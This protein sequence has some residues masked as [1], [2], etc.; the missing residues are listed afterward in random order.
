MNLVPVAITRA[1]GQNSLLLQKNS[2]KILF[3]AGIVGVVGSTVLACRATLKMDEVLSEAQDKMAMARDLD[4]AHYSEA[5][6]RK[7]IT[8]IRVQT[9]VKIVKLY[10]PALVIGG[11]SVAALT[12]SHN[13][14]SRRNAGLTAAYAALERGFDEY[15]AR[16]IA[17]YGEDEDRDLRYGTRE[18]T[19]EEKGKKKK[20]VRVGPGD[21]SIYARFFDVS[22][23]S[24]N[25]DPEYNLI[26][27]KCQQNYANDLLHARGHIFLNEVY[28]MLGIPRSKAGAVVGWVL[29]V[30]DDFVDFG[31]FDDKS[32]KARDFV[33]G[34]EGAILLDFNVDGLIY[35]RIEFEEQRSLPWRQES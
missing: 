20:V 11:L 18:I 12:S 35:D 6:R 15:R 4:H 22:S 33:N 5:D 31:V 1:I 2:P 9:A 34:F 30:G 25:K 19:V 27:L 13:I 21:P 32:N 14:L 23:P 7:D 26:F 17:K 10:G 16:V 28:D 24:W 29:G 8:V 3:G